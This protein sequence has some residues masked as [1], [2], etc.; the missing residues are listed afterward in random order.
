MENA[1]RRVQPDAINV[2]NFLYG[3]QRRI[4]ISVTRE[5]LQILSQEEKGAMRTFA[6]RLRAEDVTRLI[7]A[8]IAGRAKMAPLEG[9]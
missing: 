9:P 5:V 1:D 6:M 3:A 7:E 8:L 4:E 2:D